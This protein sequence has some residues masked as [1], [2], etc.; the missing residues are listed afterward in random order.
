MQNQPFQQPNQPPLPT[1]DGY[2]P[3]VVSIQ[4][5]GDWKSAPKIV[6]NWAYQLTWVVLFFLTIGLLAGLFSVWESAGEKVFG[7]VFTGLIAALFL[8]LGRALKNGAPAA[9][10]VQII[11]SVIGLLFFPF[12]TLVNIYVLSQWFKPETKAWFGK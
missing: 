4:T 8:W 10:T 3:P 9:W 5:G 11:V 7:V 2:L 12:W 6:K 1:P